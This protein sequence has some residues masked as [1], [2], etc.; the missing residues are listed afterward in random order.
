MTIPSGSIAL[1]TFNKFSIS[2]TS[3]CKILIFDRVL[4]VLSSK[5]GKLTFASSIVDTVQK[6]LFK[7]PIFPH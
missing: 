5:F 6:K 3:D 4:L 1:F 7:P 2:I